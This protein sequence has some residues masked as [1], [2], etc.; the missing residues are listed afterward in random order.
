MAGPVTPGKSEAKLGAPDTSQL[1]GTLGTGP[2][3]LLQAGVQKDTNLTNFVTE[4]LFGRRDRV[5]AR[6]SR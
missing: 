2:T 4:P 3:A 5:Q 6:R 1:S